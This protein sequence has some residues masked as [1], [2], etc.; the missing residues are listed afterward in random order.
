M[1]DG[2]ARCA[3]CGETYPLGE[4]GPGSW[5]WY[6]EGERMYFRHCRESQHHMEWGRQADHAMATTLG[7][8][9]TAIW[10]GRKHQKLM[11]SRTAQRLREL[12]AS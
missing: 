12:L 9:D 3:F 11:L 8:L 10:N 4:Q 2:S 5:T 1:T 6:P 7:Q